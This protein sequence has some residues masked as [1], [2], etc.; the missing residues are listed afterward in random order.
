MRTY[1]RLCFS[2]W[3]RKTTEGPAGRMEDQGLLGRGSHRNISQ[4]NELVCWPLSKGAPGSA[5]TPGIGPLS[6]AEALHRKIRALPS[7]HGKCS[8]GQVHRGGH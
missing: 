2:P 3:W 5:R 1:P 8:R 4:R 7:H 6:L